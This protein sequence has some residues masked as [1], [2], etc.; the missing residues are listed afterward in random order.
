VVHP[1]PFDSAPGLVKR[2]VVANTGDE[3]QE[4][5]RPKKSVVPMTRMMERVS[6]TYKEKRMIE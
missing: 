1:A 5:R 3:E 2:L 4:K 6:I